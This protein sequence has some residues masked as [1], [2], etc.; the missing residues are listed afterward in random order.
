MVTP[1]KHKGHVYY[2]CTQY[3]GKHKTE[4]LREEEITGQFGQ[5]FKQIRIPKEVADEIMESLKNVHK[6]KSEFREQHFEQLTKE[7]DR[8][9]KR[10]EAMYLDKLDRR[11]TADEYD[12]LYK[13]FREK[14]A[15]MDTRLTNLQ[16]AEDD[17][18]LTANYLLQLTNRAYDLFVGSEIEQKRQLLKL[19]LLNPT[20]KGKNLCYDLIKPF[21]TILDYADNKLWLRRWDSNP[22]PFA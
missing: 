10:L 14:I 15:E 16:E 3:K 11:I 20:L 12:K 17:Y 21:D 7:K 9:A 6:G 8:Y 5:L 1:E 22:Q 2:H 19:I 18:Y 13:E 4:W